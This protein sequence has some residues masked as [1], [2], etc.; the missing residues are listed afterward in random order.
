M[1]SDEKSSVINEI[2]DWMI[3]KSSEDCFYQDDAVG[4]IEKKYGKKFMYENENGGLAI[5]KDILNKFRKKSSND[6]VWSRSGK[7]WR[8]RI[9][10]D[11]KG[12][13]QE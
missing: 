10:T 4:E 2:V 12:R 9:K 13:M 8:K 3:E 6:I 7:Y 5:S 11:S 1:N